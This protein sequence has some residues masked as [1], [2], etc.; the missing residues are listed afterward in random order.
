MTDTNGKVHRN[1]LKM[2]Y[3]YI[4]SFDKNIFSV[5]A[6]TENGANIKFK[7]KSAILKARNL[8]K[9]KIHKKEKLYYLNNVISLKKIK[10]IEV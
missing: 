8:T 1:I 3:I 2:Y 5:Q 10:H 4:P 6:A 7:L 9:F